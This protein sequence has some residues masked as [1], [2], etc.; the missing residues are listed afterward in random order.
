ML[1]QVSFRMTI[2]L[3]TVCAEKTSSAVSPLP[4]DFYDNFGGDPFTDDAPHNSLMR[5]VFIRMEQPY[6]RF[7]AAMALRVVCTWP[8]YPKSPGMWWILSFIT[9]KCSIDR[10]LFFNNWRMKTTTKVVKNMLPGHEK[11]KIYTTKSNLGGVSFV[12]LYL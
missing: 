2:I 4:E 3:F 1:W 9:G 12:G 11:L 5:S 7:Y 10:A 8:H 6:G